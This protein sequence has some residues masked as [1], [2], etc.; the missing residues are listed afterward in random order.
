[1]KEYI[2]AMEIDT[3]Y[4]IKIALIDSNRLTTIPKLNQLSWYDCNNNILLKDT[5]TIYYPK[6]NGSYAVIYS[7][8][9]LSND[10]SSCYTFK[11]NNLNNY[12]LDTISI[13]PNPTTGIINVNF[14][15]LNLKYELIDELGSIIKADEVKEK[16][17][18]SEI[19]NG[20]YQMNIFNEKSFITFKIIK[21]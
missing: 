18:F 4:N 1:M 15:T 6:S 2:H 14:D 8:N 9:C 19:T 21:I 13:S 17:D 16:I 3:T 10:T 7:N 12:N 5:S 20:I 11:L